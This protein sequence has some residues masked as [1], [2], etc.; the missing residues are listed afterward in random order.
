MNK[1]KTMGLAVF[2]AAFI[3]VPA[4]GW[5]QTPGQTT[6]PLVIEPS[7]YVEGYLGFGGSSSTQQ[8][9]TGIL[10]GDY[11]NYFQGGGK[12]G[13]WFT[14]QGTY[15]ASWYQDWMKYLGFYTDLSYHSLD[16]PNGTVEVSGTGFATGNSS[17][18][19]WT[20]GFM[21]A[22]RYGFLEDSEVPFGRLQP[23]IGLGPAIFF[24]G[25]DY[26]IGGFTGGRN[27]SI[28]IGLA[29]E[30]GFRYFFTNNISAE[31]SFKY[32]HFE[33]SYY[34]SPLGTNIQP[35]VNLLSGQFGLAYHF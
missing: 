35:N 18:Y 19:V 11:D 26:N 16:H 28:N 21:F 7:F 27:S 5:A 2:L 17:G 31:A 32:R 33:P 13:Y 9:N 23:Y 34:F 15:A 29:I 8:G 25:Q 30:T 6:K 24:S 20:W 3:L 22:G 10:K 1:V 4:M 14:P 12:F